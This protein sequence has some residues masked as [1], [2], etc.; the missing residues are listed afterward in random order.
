[1]PLKYTTDLGILERW[2]N[3]LALLARRKIFDIFAR[4]LAPAPDARVADF[5]VSGHDEHPVHY[6]FEDMYPYTEN[7]SAI[8]REAEEAG[9]MSARF[10]GLTF[11]EADLRSIPVPDGYFDAGI[12]NAVVEHAGSRSDQQALVREVCRVCRNVLFT[13]P[14]KRFPLELHTFLPIVHWLPD[15]AFRRSLRW[16]GMDYFAE[17][18]NLNPLD[19]HEFL[20]L[21][22]TNRENRLAPK[23][24][25]GSGILS[26][27]LLCISS[28]SDNKQGTSV[29]PAV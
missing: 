8:G 1:M 12:C 6:F 18:D 15:P 3:D 20:S 26:P 9:W 11:I 14:N 7:L 24:P 16:L 13:T 21:F 22:P 23:G 5:G 10:P 4:E 28:A 27:N 25:L 29:E 19:P 2:K 17:L